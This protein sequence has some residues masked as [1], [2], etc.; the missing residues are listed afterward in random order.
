MFI[1][2]IVGIL[3]VA[4]LV[5]FMVGYGMADLKHKSEKRSSFKWGM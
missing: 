5:A 1:G 2:I 3:I 4:G